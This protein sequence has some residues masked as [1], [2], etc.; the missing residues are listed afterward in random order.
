MAKR[1]TVCT[2]PP[3]EA[4]IVRAGSV[5][6]RKVTW[7]VHRLPV[8]AGGDA[9]GRTEGLFGRR[10]PYVDPDGLVDSGDPA[11]DGDR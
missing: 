9:A 1:S 5:A 7:M 8:T 2:W 10:L 11:G 3:V 4:T 6:P